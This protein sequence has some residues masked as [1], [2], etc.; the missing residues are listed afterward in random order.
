MQDTVERAF[1]MLDTYRPGT[2][3]GAWMRTI[4]YRLAVD[5]TRRQRRDRVARREYAAQNAEQA[6][7]LER[8]AEAEHPLPTLAEVR[9]AATRLH[10]PFRTT[11]DLWAVKGLSYLEISRELG[12]PVGTVATRLLRARRSLLEVFPGRVS[13][14]RPR[15]RRPACPPRSGARASVY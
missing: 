2:S 13:A 14:A 7:P 3:A 11:F 5:G 15:R 8:Q 9:A 1:R 10:E 6:E 4:M 12:V